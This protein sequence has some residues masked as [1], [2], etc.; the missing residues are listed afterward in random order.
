M[1]P[2]F[3]IGKNSILIS[4]IILIISVLLIIDRLLATG[5]VQLILA[6]GKA[7]PIESASL[8]SI[9]EVLFF[10]ITA[11]LGG[12]SFLYIILNSKEIPE[13][14]DEEIPESKREIPVF[15]ESKSAL[16]AALLEGDEKVLFQ[17]VLD[18]DG[19][20]Q[21]ELITK[22]GFSEPKVSRLLDKAQRKGLIIRQ[23]DGMG[24]RVFLK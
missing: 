5:P 12:M 10:I 22:T 23:R 20:L 6:D 17:N 8:F 4:A 19:I 15:Q 24:N 21:R 14:K 7:V 18:N 2:K 3:T 16:A 1:T 9:N 13:L 11:W